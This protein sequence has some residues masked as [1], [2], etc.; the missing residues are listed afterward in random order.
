[1]TALILWDESTGPRRR[2]CVTAVRPFPPRPVSRARIM[3][4]ARTCSVDGCGKP[5]KARSWCKTHYYR[6]YRHGDPA[7]GR[8]P[9]GEAQRFFREIVL[10]FAGDECLIW[11]YARS[12]DGYGRIKRDGHMQN[13]SRLACEA[14]YGEAPTPEHETAHLC[15]KGHE[16]CVNPWHLRWAT[17]AENEAD[18]LIH[19]TLS[20]IRG[21][22][23]GKAKLDEH[24]IL[25]I[26]A[27]RDKMPQREIAE[28][29][30]VCRSQV[31]S[32]H[33]GENWGWLHDF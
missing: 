16:S 10:Q 25:E 15:G 31:G 7:A 1:M 13:V 19:G 32:I 29:F 30:G 3:T 4:D 17:K 11:P 18:K 21:E 2:V 14:I 6:W 9:P 28:R 23:N 20:R 8:I 27:L 12:G 33:R 26:L 5:R 24:S 22:R